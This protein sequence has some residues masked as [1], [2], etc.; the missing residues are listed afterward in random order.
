MIYIEIQ[1]LTNQKYCNY[2]A[3]TVNLTLIILYITI[4]KNLNYSNYSILKINLTL[5]I[6]SNIKLTKKMLTLNLEDICLNTCMYNI[7]SVHGS[8]WWRHHRRIWELRTESIEEIML[9][10]RDGDSSD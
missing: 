3:N 4:Q 8:G 1:Y 5:I 2:I 9:R 6:Y 10:S 7:Y